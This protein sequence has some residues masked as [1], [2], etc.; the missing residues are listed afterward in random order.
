[1]VGIG[2]Q[3]L[4]YQHVSEPIAIAERHAPLYREVLVFDGEHWGLGCYMGHGT[5]SHSRYPVLGQCKATYWAELPR[6]PDRVDA[7]TGE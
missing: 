4:R 6:T 1:M 5:Y 2:E 3:L 7:A